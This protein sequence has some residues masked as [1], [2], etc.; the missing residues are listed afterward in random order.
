MGLWRGT[1]IMGHVPLCPEYLI[2]GNDKE[3]SCACLVYIIV[4][5]IYIYAFLYVNHIKQKMYIKYRLGTDVPPEDS[6]NWQSSDWNGGKYSK[7]DRSGCSTS[8]A[9]PRQETTKSS[10]HSLTWLGTIICEEI[11]GHHACTIPKR[12]FTRLGKASCWVDLINSNKIKLWI[13][14]EKPPSHHV[15]V[16]D[17]RILL[18]PNRCTRGS[19]TG[20][21]VYRRPARTLDG[22][23]GQELVRWAQKWMEAQ[24]QNAKRGW[25]LGLLAWDQGTWTVMIKGRVYIVYIMDGPNQRLIQWVIPRNSSN[26]SLKF[27]HWLSKKMTPWTRFIYYIYI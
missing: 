11:F 8:H 26:K 13:R 4:L 23:G 17:W 16:G 22:K 6:Y 5:Y 27:R 15:W 2:Q 25:R 21:T 7:T 9:P 18:V 24:P 19:V 3:I 12:H 20:P 10:R 14:F 1:A